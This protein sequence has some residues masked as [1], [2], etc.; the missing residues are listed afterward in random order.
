MLT[1]GCGLA[2]DAGTAVGEAE[3][4]ADEPHGPVA[5]RHRLEDVARLEL[6]MTGDL[7]DLPD[8]GARHVGRG[9]PGLPALWLIG[10]QRRLDHLAQGLVVVRARPP[11]A[12]ARILERVGATDG[13]HEAR[14]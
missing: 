2:L 12:E 6:R 13:A 8:D 5:C 1:E 14:E 3:T 7:V 9:E 11:V 4:G 10:G